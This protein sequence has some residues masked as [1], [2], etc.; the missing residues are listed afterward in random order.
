MMKKYNEMQSIMKTEQIQIEIAEMELENT[1][2]NAFIMSCNLNGILRYESMLGIIPNPYDTLEARQ[3]RVMARW[4]NMMPYTYREL[5]KMLDVLCG[6]G[7][8]VLAPDFNNYSLGIITN[9]PLSSQLEEL[10]KLIYNIIPCNLVVKTKN[11]IQIKTTATIYLVPTTT[12]TC[13]VEIET[14]PF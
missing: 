11:V 12:T 1:V 10:E 7:N 5:I 2:N 3:I 8:Y 4:N 9:L 14:K 6:K 13:V